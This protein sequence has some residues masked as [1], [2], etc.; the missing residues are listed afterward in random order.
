MGTC[1]AAP[2]PVAINPAT[3]AAGSGGGT[4]ADFKFRSL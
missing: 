4:F 2:K 3:I 1:S